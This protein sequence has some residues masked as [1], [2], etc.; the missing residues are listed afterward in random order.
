MCIV[1]KGPR[2]LCC[3]VPENSKVTCAC[4]CYFSIVSVAHCTCMQH[5]S[6]LLMLSLKCSQWR[7]PQDCSC[8]CVFQVPIPDTSTACMHGVLEFLYCGLLTPCPGLEPMELIVLANRLC[9]PRL[10]ALTG[11]VSP[12]QPH[13]CKKK[14]LQK[15]RF[16]LSQEAGYW[17]DDI[18]PCVIA[19]FLSMC[20]DPVL[21]VLCDP[22]EQ[23]AVDELLQLAVKGGDID[24][25]VLAYLELAQ[26]CLLN[27]VPSSLDSLDFRNWRL[28]LCSSTLK[29]TVLFCSSTM[30][31][32]CQLGVSITSAPIITASA[33][34]FLKT[35]R[36]CH[37]VLS[38]IPHFKYKC[39]LPTGS[40][41]LLFQEAKKVLKQKKVGTKLAVIFPKSVNKNYVLQ[42]EHSRR[43]PFQLFNFRRFPGL[44]LSSWN[45]TRCNTLCY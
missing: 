34:S 15:T 25:Q 5:C 8:V 43:V 42:R 38:K 30:P 28:E 44:T 27:D 6:V 20:V 12:L 14:G 17:D 1:P 35:W 16:L 9:L 37:Q 45:F 36:P 39:N 13:E 32:S 26:V 10:V 23:H 31:S 22:V 3:L 24:G 21:S 33:A 11:T 29:A 41:F 2:V 7:L 40:V 4:S 19:S 18:A